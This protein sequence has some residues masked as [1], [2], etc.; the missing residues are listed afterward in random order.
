MKRS[1]LFLAAFLV[2]TGAVHGAE[3]GDLI[4]GEKISLELKN[5]PITSV[6]STLGKETGF[7]IVAGTG[8]KGKVTISLKDV[9]P[10]DAFNSVLNSSGYSYIIDGNIIR[11]MPVTG[12]SSGGDNEISYDGGK[13]TKAFSVSNITADD[14]RDMISSFGYPNTK[15]LS[16]KGSNVFVVESPGNIMKK[17]E[18]I[19][20]RVDSVP[21]QVLVE[22][23]IMEITAGNSA[24]PTTMGIRA[25][26]TGST[27]TAQTEGLADPATTGTAGFY[28]HVVKGGLDA[29]LET[30]EHKE[31]FNLLANPKVVAVSGKPANIIS[32]SK[33]GYKTTLTTTTGTVQNIDF[34]EV[35]TKLSFTPY[36]SSD[37]TIKMEI[38]PEVSEGTIT[39]DGLPQKQ[40]TEATTT[41]VVR[42]GETIIIGGLIKN[43]SNEGYTGVPVI[44]NIPLIGNFFK[45]KEI[46]WE[47]KE[48]I[49]MLTPHIITPQKL[50]QMA[51][52]IK[53]MEDRQ[54]DNGTGEEP[55]LMWWV[56]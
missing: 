23:R 30:L 46:L 35:G 8:V 28:A 37:G 31:G 29:Y 2:L 18:R 27:Y 20:S 45:K 19:I 16:A 34:L 44:M 1:I 49:A 9:A 33:L 4:K 14:A 36:I 56:K 40:T 21:N 52:E 39:T 3:V 54:K 12:A 42:D 50:K 48:I 13:F 7:N 53:N 55:G 6:L 51:G 22:S 15:V 17:I 11:V 26:Y 25:K 32:G 43:K 5:A 10:V 24:V 47:K 38:H 41:V